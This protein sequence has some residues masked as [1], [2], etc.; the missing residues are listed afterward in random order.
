MAPTDVWSWHHAAEF[1]IVD[2]MVKDD[3]E[4]SIGTY[5]DPELVGPNS[6]WRIIASDHYE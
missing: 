3:D 5:E 6:E 1:R 4:S 2:P